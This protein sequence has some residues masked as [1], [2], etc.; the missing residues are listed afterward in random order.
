MGISR[1]R[2]GR[3]PESSVSPTS[4]TAGGDGFGT[5]RLLAAFAIIVDHTAPLTRTGGSVLPSA[6]GVDLGVIA[7]AAFMAMSGY[8]VTRSWE[9]DPSAWRFAVRRTL[10]IVPGLVVVLLAAAFVLGPLLT[11]LPLR[12]YLGHP[13]TF[14]YLTN[15]LQLF[16]QQYALPGVFTGNPYPNAVNGSLWSLPVEV[17]GYAIVLA[18]GLFGLLRRRFVLVL[19]AVVFAAAFQR[20]LTRQI[21]PPKTLLMIPTAPLLQYLAVYCVG[22]AAYLYRDRIRFSWAGVLI[23][24]G[25]DVVMHGSAMAE[26]VRL[27]TVPY[28]VLTIGE[29]LP[30]RLWLPSWLTV[31]SYGVYLYGFPTEQ[32]VL[33]VGVRSP[34]MVA[35]VA[36]PIALALGLLSWHVV[37]SPAMKLRRYLFRRGR[38]RPA[39]APAAAVAPATSAAPPAAAAPAAAP[40]V[41]PLPASA[42]AP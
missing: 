11:T 27:V 21:V 3:S 7:V 32:A 4:P 37:E 8:H 13:K 36:V 5:V 17:L 41:Q 24:V 31:A 10:R 42:T 20:I 30:R 34:M 25:I 18:A 12:D 15:N 35:L 14:S 28:V 2:L 26:I 16:P 33:H 29:L 19:A 9:R 23:C 6:F 22:M 40:A 1:L 39:R 38:T